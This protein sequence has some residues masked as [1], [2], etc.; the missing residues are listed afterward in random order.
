M[1]ELIGTSPLILVVDDGPGTRRLAK[2]RS[3]AV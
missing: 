3:F 1:T 2:E